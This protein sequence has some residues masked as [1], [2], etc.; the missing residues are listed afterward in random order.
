[1]RLT[2]VYSFKTGSGFC[3]GPDMHLLNIFMELIYPPIPEYTILYEKHLTCKEYLSQV[4]QNAYVTFYVCGFSILL[5]LAL[6]VRSL[7]NVEK[8]FFIVI[9][10][11]MI[12]GMLG[13]CATMYLFW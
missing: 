8:R 6:M 3:V 9:L 1:M 4:K 5:T 11:C 7:F 12:L 2:L 10:S 13:T